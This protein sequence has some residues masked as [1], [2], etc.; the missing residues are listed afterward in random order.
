M[1]LLTLSFHSI[2]WLGPEGLPSPCLS[3]GRSVGHSVT[4]ALCQITSGVPVS[5]QAPVLPTPPLPPAAIYGGGGALCIGSSSRSIFPGRR[6]QLNVPLALQ[7][8]PARPLSNSLLFPS[9]SSSRGRAAGGLSQ[10]LSLSR[11]S[12]TLALSRPGAASRAEAAA[13]ATGAATAYFH[14]LTEGVLVLFAG[15]S[16][17]LQFTS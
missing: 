7:L 15:L 6:F 4:C 17:G 9:S 16:V 12:A 11:T 13:A 14:R 8:P 2:L 1:F 10:R 3:L 5:S